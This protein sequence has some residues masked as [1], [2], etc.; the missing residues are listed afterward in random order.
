MVLSEY[1]KRL[2]EVFWKRLFPRFPKNYEIYKKK[3]L[4]LFNILKEPLLVQKQTIPQQKA[5]DLN[6]NLAPWKWAWHHNYAATLSS[7]KITFFTPDAHM[8]FAAS[9]C[10][11]LLRM[12]QPFS[13]CQIKAEIKGFLLRYRLLL[14][15]L[16]QWKITP[17]AGLSSLGVPG[18]PWHTQILADQLTL[19][20]PG[21]QIMP[22]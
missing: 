11:A 3:P 1:W 22:T 12:P 6:F 18:V 19:F 20:Q 2:E 17:T 9:R 10:G 7:N 15:Y 8:L 13:V 16:S 4:A 5:L 14:Y 21:E